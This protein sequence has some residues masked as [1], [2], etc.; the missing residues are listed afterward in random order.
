MKRVPGAARQLKGNVSRK[1][2]L[3]S[4]GLQGWEHESW[5]GGKKP[6]QCLD[7]LA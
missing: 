7:L 4:G 1:I 2:M 5:V 3:G 6:A